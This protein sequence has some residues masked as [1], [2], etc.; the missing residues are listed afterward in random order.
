MNIEPIDGV[1]PLK[2]NVESFLVSPNIPPVNKPAPGSFFS[3][4]FYAYPAFFYYFLGPTYYLNKPF[5]SFAPKAGIFAPK[6][7][8]VPP[9]EGNFCS[10][11][12]FLTGAVGSFEIVLADVSGTSISSALSAAYEAFIESYFLFY[13]LG[14][15]GGIN[16]LS[17]LFN[18]TNAYNLW[19]KGFVEGET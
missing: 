14:K 18:P 8:I 9:N 3:I 17:S 10:F 2:F 5:L 4:F 6:A 15:F 19:S 7:G 16:F 1:G 11:V 13:I 12:Y